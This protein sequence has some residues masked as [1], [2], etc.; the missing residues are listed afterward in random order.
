MSIDWLEKLALRVDRGE[1]FF[2]CPGTGRNEWF[3]STDLSELRTKAQKTA[4]AQRYDAGLYRLVNKGDVTG[5]D[6]FLVVRTIMDPG[7]RGEPNLKWCL[8]DTKDAADM[9]RDVSQG[10]SPFFGA[11]LEETFSPS[12]TRQG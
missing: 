10:P 4:N 12:K 7:G 11:V 8:V 3:V 9:L 1:E 6:G 2:A 5:G